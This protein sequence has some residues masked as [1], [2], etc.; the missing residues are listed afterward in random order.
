[1]ATCTMTPWDLCSRPSFH[2]LFPCRALSWHNQ[3][4]SMSMRRVGTRLCSSYH[5]DARWTG[6]RP[7]WWVCR[8]LA[9]G[10]ARPRLEFRYNSHRPASL[11]RGKEMALTDHRTEQGLVWRK[12]EYVCVYDF[13]AV[14]F[15]VECLF[16]LRIITREVIAQNT[17]LEAD[18]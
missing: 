17:R 6:Q 16:V 13:P 14:I 9:K 4:R 11:C 5:G 1:M 12:S 10:I 3:P 2:H 8:W 15:V 18:R 7:P